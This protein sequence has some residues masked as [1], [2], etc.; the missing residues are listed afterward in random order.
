[1][2]TRKFQVCTGHQYSFF[3]FFFTSMYLRGSVVNLCRLYQSYSFLFLDIKQKTKKLLLKKADLSFR[4][5]KSF[6][7][8][9]HYKHRLNTWSRGPAAPASRLLSSDCKCYFS[10][11][12]WRGA[13][14]PALEMCLQQD[15]D[16][17]ERGAQCLKRQIVNK[18][19]Q[20]F[21]WLPFSS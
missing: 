14:I 15:V 18:K 7:Q 16:V 11:P 17:A 10:C 9:C 5:S 3:L 4:N 20:N 2:S 21:P 1:M 8:L 19:K 13:N 12:G 6:C